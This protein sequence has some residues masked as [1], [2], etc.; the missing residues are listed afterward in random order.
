M[1]RDMSEREFKAA[2]KRH[3]F[4]EIGPLGYVKLPGTNTS[5][6]IFGKG[7]GRLR[8]TLAYLLREKSKAQAEME[9]ARLAQPTEG[10][11]Q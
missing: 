1:A 3:G 10:Q 11:Q 8:A 5:V 7:S 2:M 9:L 6:S 4:G